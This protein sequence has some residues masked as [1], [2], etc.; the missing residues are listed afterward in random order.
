MP[1]SDELRLRL[2]AAA[3]RGLIPRRLRRPP[4]MIRPAAIERKFRERLL[5]IIAR[6]QREWEKTILPHLP[7]LVQE[8]AAGRPKA[9]STHADQWADE[10]ARLIAALRLNLGRGKPDTMRLTEA[11]ADD[12]GNWND[13]EWRKT[14]KAVLG[15]DII[16]A[17]PWLRPELAGWAKENASLIT[18]LEGEAVADVE[19]WT[20]RGLRSGQRHEQIRDKILERFEV[21]ESRAALIARD[22]VSKING[23]LTQRRQT[24]LGVT[25][26]VWRTSGDERV[27]ESHREKNGK[28][29]KWSEPPADTGHPG[30]D[31]QCRCTAEPVLEGLL[32]GLQEAA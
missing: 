26:Y 2:K 4:R 14:L 8:A 23:E 30:D 25:E 27:R 29:F 31:F 32:A 21:S 9:D 13:I 12:I 1:I 28:T 22:Q 5:E 17:E 20:L 3:R 7:G 18:S 19:R 24:A 6:V 16:Q 11:F 10:A 15:V